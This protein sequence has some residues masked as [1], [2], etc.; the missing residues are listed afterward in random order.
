MLN[1]PQEILDALERATPESKSQAI[2]ALQ[3]TIQKQA[4]IINAARDVV[5]GADYAMQNLQ[6]ALKKYER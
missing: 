6:K 5:A 2:Y 1:S 4:D 3:L